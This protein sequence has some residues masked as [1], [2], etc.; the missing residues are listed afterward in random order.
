MLNGVPVTTPDILSQTNERLIEVTGGLGVPVASITA[1]ISDATFR[2]ETTTAASTRL[3]A[4]TGREQ[5]TWT[6][7]YRFGAD[8][9]D[10]CDEA[11]R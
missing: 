11:F 5:S 3:A 1:S 7:V 2:F 9:E 10:Q 4:V 8:P 6:T